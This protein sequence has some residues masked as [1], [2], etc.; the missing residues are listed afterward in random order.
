MAESAI[1][2]ATLEL[3]GQLLAIFGL[4]LLAIAGLAVLV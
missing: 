2:Q 1:R 3:L 4:G